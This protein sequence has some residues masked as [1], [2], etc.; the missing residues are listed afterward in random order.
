MQIISFPPYYQQV[1]TNLDLSSFS[2]ISCTPTVALSRLK[3]G[4]FANLE[5]PNE[6]TGGLFRWFQAGFP[7]CLESFGGSVFV[8]IINRH[9][10]SCGGLSAN[11]VGLSLI[12]RFIFPSNNRPW[13]I[14]FLSKNSR[15]GRVCSHANVSNLKQLGISPLSSLGEGPGT[16]L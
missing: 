3:C 13:D 2:L 5:S 11:L 15:Y 8:N 12:H 16:R 10:T 9:P 6:K 4:P 1:C 7:F 14:F